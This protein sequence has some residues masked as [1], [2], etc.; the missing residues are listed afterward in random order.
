MNLTGEP[1]DKSSAD[2][3]KADD[4]LYRTSRIVWSALT[5]SI[6]AYFAVAMTLPPVGSA[7]NEAV[8]RVLMILAAA[9]V[10]VS[11]PAKRWLMAQAEQ[12]DSP[13]LRKFALLAPLILCD[14]AGVTG[15]VLRIVTGSTHYYLFL[16]L[17]LAGMLLNY[18]RRPA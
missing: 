6:V 13:Q 2:R 15:L 1:A 4:A 7:G 3:Q 18:P 12:V 9:Y 16:G 8:E 14:V 10:V 11:I 5:A 17:A